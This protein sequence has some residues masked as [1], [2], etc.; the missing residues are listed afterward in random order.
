LLI[1]PNIW[2]PIGARILAARGYPAVA[3]ASAA[4][5]ASLGYPDGE[6]IQRSTLIR[7][8]ERIAR[9][10]DVPVTADIETGYGASVSDLE[11]TIEQV[12]ESGVVGVNI[13]D[14]LGKGGDLRTVEEQC[15]RLS[16]VRHVADRLGVPLVIN[17]RVDSFISPAFSD[18]EQAMEEAV[19]RARAYTAAGADCI[20]PIGPGDEPSVRLL[21]ERIPSPINILGS[22]TAVPLS[23]LRE[24]G[25]NRVSFGPYVFRSCM[26]KFLDIAEGLLADQDYR[27]LGEPM[28]RDEVA[29][30]LRD[31]SE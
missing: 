23:T 12:I 29:G 10:V 14:R 31:E 17:A 22:P 19:S 27:S 1:L 20:Y 7:L 3:T 5:S 26:R 28:S 16:A 25:I 6:M 13:E 4:V 24:I 11:E 2:D 15:E 8:L 30:F 9:S 21:R 18:R